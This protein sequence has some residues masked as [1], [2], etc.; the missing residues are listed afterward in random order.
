M[1]YM[2]EELTDPHKVK[3]RRKKMEE[4]VKNPNA[5][6]STDALKGIDSEE[7]REPEPKTP[8]YFPYSPYSPYHLGTDFGE[9]SGYASPEP[10][11][12]NDPDEPI[13]NSTGWEVEPYAGTED[14]PIKV[15]SDEDEGESSQVRVKPYGPLG[16]S[17][18]PI[19]L[20]AY[21]SNQMHYGYGKIKE[22]F[23]GPYGMDTSNYLG[24]TYDRG[25]CYT[26]GAYPPL[27][28]YFSMTDL[29]L[30]TSD[31]EY[32]PLGRPYVP[33]MVR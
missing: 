22:E 26:T 12:T 3:E 15:Y 30:G 29:T 10:W 11:E 31:P 32:I 13:E 33:E 23:G 2:L 8:T 25:D 21:D 20:E 6:Y 1:E 17:T 5:A 19:D 24:S 14:D 16:R 28:G 18:N 9:P 7:E 4:D 27:E